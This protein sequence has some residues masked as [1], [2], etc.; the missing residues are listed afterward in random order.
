M[1]ELLQDNLKKVFS[2]QEI[3]LENLRE[4]DMFTQPM[5]L[6][7]NKRYYFS[8]IY[9]LF[10]SMLLIILVLITLIDNAFFP[11][12]RYVC[13]LSV[14]STIDTQEYTIIM[15]KELVLFVTLNDIKNVKLTLK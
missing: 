8:T 4:I 6:T 1:S 7:F 13:P 3:F 5:A 11:N 9:G 10:F 14:G 12:Y 15:G 2:I